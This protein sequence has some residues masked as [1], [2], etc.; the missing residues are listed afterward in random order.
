[1]RRRSRAAGWLVGTFTV[2]LFLL[3]PLATSATHGKRVWSGQWT[4][5]TGGVGFRWVTDSEGL[6]AI[7]S[8]GG[9]PCAEP[10]DYFR[11]GYV[12]GS[13]RGKVTGCTKGNKKHLIAR[14][15]SDKSGSGT[16][17][18]TFAEPASFRGTYTTDARATGPYTGSFRGHFGGDGAVGKV[19]APVGEPV[20]V[21]IRFHANN[22]GTAPPVDGGAC[23]GPALKAA[24]INGTIM[25]RITEIRLE[26][27]G[28]GSVTDTPHLSPCRAPVIKIAVDRVRFRVLIPGRIVRATLSVHI[29][30]E[31]AH[32]PGQC[33]V[34]TRGTIEATYNDTTQA[35]N[36]LPN[37][38]LEIGPWAGPC[39]AHTHVITNNISSIGAGGSSST[40]VR[41][42]IGCQSA[43]GGG[44]APRNCGT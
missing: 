26:H 28:S 32:R 5:N 2:A 16:F 11:G 8:Q 34:G 27:Q 33:Q 14:Y 18:I 24:R 22:L 15:V 42:W 10:T 41:V 21:D 38:R 23:P 30:Q 44:F 25:A 39:A 6:A 37:H 1:M 20:R 9:K 17:D 19:E 35:A 36:S 4:T 13:D 31:G 7:K 43:P 12:A 40:W 29:D 3:F